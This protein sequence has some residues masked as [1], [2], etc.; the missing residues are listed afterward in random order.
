MSISVKDLD[1]ELAEEVDVEYEYTPHRA[2]TRIEPEE[3]GVTITSVW[4]YATGKAHGTRVDIQS[5]ISKRL[6]EKWEEEIWES[7]QN[8]E[9]EYE[10]D[11]EDDR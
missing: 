7:I 4:L 10:K 1:G 6:L 11:L 9:P 3:G 5:I 2:A 8:H